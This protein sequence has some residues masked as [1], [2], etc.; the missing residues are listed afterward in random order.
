MQMQSEQFKERINKIE[1]CADDAKGAVQQGQVSPE[2][3]QSVE[4]LHQQAHEQ[5]AQVDLTPE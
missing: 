4:Q 3:R 1:E 2:L 5:R